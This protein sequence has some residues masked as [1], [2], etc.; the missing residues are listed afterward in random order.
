MRGV[1]NKVQPRFLHH[2]KH[3]LAVADVHGFMPVVGDFTAQ[4]LQNPACIAFR[5]KEYSAVIAVDPG[6]AESLASE[7]DRNLGTDK[8]GGT[9]H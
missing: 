3:A 8:A 2:A 7:E 9:S 6:H 1:D 5:A 4:T